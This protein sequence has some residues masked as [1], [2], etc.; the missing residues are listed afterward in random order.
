MQQKHMLYLQVEKYIILSL[1]SANLKNYSM[2][3]SIIPMFSLQFAYIY[4]HGFPET[5]ALIGSKTHKPNCS[6]CAIF[7]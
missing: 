1:L 2:T 4:P 7:V 6:F 5:K 3:H